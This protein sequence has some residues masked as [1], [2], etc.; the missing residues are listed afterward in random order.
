MLE[1]K[2]FRPEDGFNST[3]WISNCAY[4]ISVYVSIEV[5]TPHGGLAT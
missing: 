4:L 1:L 5:S 3:R 2:V